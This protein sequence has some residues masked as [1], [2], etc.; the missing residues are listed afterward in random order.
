[1]MGERLDCDLYWENMGIMVNWTAVT[2]AGRVFLKGTT[3]HSVNLAKHSEF[4]KEAKAANLRV[5]E[6]DPFEF[7]KAKTEN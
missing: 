7:L 5:I 2:E 4:L 1:M 3:A 6:F